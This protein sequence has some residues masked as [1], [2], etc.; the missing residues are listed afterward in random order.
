MSVQVN[1]LGYLPD[2]DKLAVSTGQ[3][4][5]SFRLVS[6]EGEVIFTG[7]SSELKFWEP[8]GE[9]VSLADFSELQQPGAYQLQVEGSDP[10]AVQ[11]GEDVFE[12]IHDAAIK[13]YYF[14]RASVQL[15]PEFA[16]AWARPAGHPDDRVRVHASAASAERPAG[17][18]IAGPKGWY[19]AGDYNKYIVN[20]GVSTYTLLQAWNDF[21]DFYRQ[22]H[23]QIPE[24]A[25]ELP[26]LIDEILW[27]LEWMR[28]MQ[29]PHDG[30]VYH[31]LTTLNFAAAV[32]PH[33]ATAQRYVV[34]KTTAAALNYAAVMASASRVFE[35]FTQQHPGLADDYRQSAELAWQWAVENPGVIYQQPED[36]ST[37]AYG[38]QQLEDEFSWAAAELYLATGNADYLQA[39]FARD[40]EIKEASWSHVAAL[41]YYSLATSD[42][43]SGEDKQR[44]IQRIVS[45]ADK[46]LAQ[47]QQSAY[48]VA[49]VEEDFVWGS[50]GVA[51]NKAVLVYQAWQLSGEQGYLQV[52]QG[53][54]DY[55]LG[56]N[57]TG[58]SYVTGYG[59]KTPMHIH[60]RQS[61]AD[62]I[63]E[64]VPGWL[65]GGPQP[66]WQDECSYPSRLPA[67][68]YVDDWC[69]YSTNEV[70][71]NWNAPLVYLLAAFSS[72]S[73]QESP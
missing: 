23:W 11:I 26:D 48:G 46:M 27:N 43:L 14:N 21:E 41:G 20:S 63:S 69:S 7:F 13:A 17:T 59:H 65:A 35:D 39:F 19:D 6:Q 1:Q 3:G 37:G 71:I 58:Y 73:Q 22:R 8:A 34:Q 16:G 53:L 61:E 72:D 45:A 50:N 29:D 55:V 67:K 33:E 25:N 12:Q 2:G 68:S 9:Q 66:G 18:E 5:Q 38:D 54:L 4:N 62:D 51:L 30:G 56:R 36:V 47:H 28:A 57:P 49:M 70:T 31:K 40:K 52:A 44:V 60:H 15:T 64:P 32:M 24:S 42:S 10:I